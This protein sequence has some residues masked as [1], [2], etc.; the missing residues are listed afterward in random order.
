[1]TTLAALI[2]AALLVSIFTAVGLLLASLF[3][4][5]ERQLLILAAALGAAA[6][7]H[8]LLTGGS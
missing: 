1:M 4:L 8:Y 5:T 7:L 6:I 2:I 3:Q